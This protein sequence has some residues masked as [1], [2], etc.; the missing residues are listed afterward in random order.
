[1]YHPLTIDK[2]EIS[3]EPFTITYTVHFPKGK[4]S[5]R[6]VKVSYLTN[7]IERE[8]E[9]QDIDDEEEDE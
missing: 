9:A 4:D 5:E 1:M 3:H 6:D 7:I 2:H 8:F